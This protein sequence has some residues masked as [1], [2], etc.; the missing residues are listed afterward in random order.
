MDI[1]HFCLDLRI[2]FWTEQNYLMLPL[3]IGLG[4]VIRSNIYWDWRWCAVG[5]SNRRCDSLLSYLGLPFPIKLGENI[6]PVADKTS[7]NSDLM[8]LSLL[9]KPQEY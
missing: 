4:G 9:R 3:I 6:N 8:S 7:F 1:R 5:R 2:K